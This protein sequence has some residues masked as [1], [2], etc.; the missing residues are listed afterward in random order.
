MPGSKILIYA[1]MFLFLISLVNAATIYG[2]IYDLSLKKIDN[3]RVEIST[4]PKQ[5]IVAQNGS[6][7]FNVPNGA[8]TIKAQ[9]IQRNAVLASVQENIT[10]KQDGS[11][12]LDLILFPDIEEGIEEIDVEL[13]DE[14]IDLEKDNFIV[15]V[16]LSVIIAT[17]LIG[18][19][20][21]YIKN[22]K[23]KKEEK[24]ET[25]AE[26]KHEEAREGNDLNQLIKIIEKEGG[27]TTQKEIRK[28]IPL[29]E[30]KISLMIAELEHKGV[31]EKIKKGRGNIIILKKK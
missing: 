2:T 1:L 31:I 21:Y 15:Y 7:S 17:A 13:N 9:L 25:K 27:R 26:E 8:Y 4:T 10:I 5:F 18:V 30:A 20:F 22:K 29:S 24:I 14:I 6:Y 12:V 3:A 23:Q 28:Q 11:Y 19:Y 16:I